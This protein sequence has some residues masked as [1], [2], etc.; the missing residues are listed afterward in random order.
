MCVNAGFVMQFTV[1][2]ISFYTTA[3]C[4]CTKINLLC[5]F[6][7]LHVT[8]ISIIELLLVFFLQE[9][10]PLIFL[11]HL[12]QSLCYFQYFNINRFSQGYNATLSVQSVLSTVNVLCKCKIFWNLISCFLLESFM[13]PWLHL[14]RASQH[15]HLIISM[16]KWAVNLCELMGDSR[17]K[18]SLK[19]C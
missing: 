13:L 19:S 1:H 11:C 2:M 4:W 6:L 3:Y 12:S 16:E 5:N 7:V 15:L 14:P 17:W 10:I 18:C 8:R 9:T